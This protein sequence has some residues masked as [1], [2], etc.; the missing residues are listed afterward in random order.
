MALCRSYHDMKKQKYGN[1][2][3]MIPAWKPLHDYVYAQ[4]KDVLVSN[5]NPKP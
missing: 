2:K 1:P 4:E 3:F 5:P